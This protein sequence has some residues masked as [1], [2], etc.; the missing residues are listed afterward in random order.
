MRSL[1]AVSC[2]AF[3]FRLSAPVVSLLCSQEVSSSWQPLPFIPASVPRSRLSL[4]P[5]CSFFPE[6]WLLNNKAPQMP[7]T[8]DSPPPCPLCPHLLSCPCP[9][10]QLTQ[11]HGFC[12]FQ[13]AQ[14]ESSLLIISSERISPDKDDPLEPGSPGFLSQTIP[15]DSVSQLQLSGV[16]WTLGLAWLQA[17]WLPSLRPVWVEWRQ[18]W[19]SCWLASVSP[20][21]FSDFRNAA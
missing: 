16:G 18:E 17:E 9:L 13:V 5:P 11:F 1:N 3:S 6:H 21:P 15:V 7:L 14:K 8:A 19:S 4:C 2:E 12:V 10:L 20:F